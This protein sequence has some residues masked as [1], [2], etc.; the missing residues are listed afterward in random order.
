MFCQGRR[1]T[2]AIVAS[3]PGVAYQIPVVW[4]VIPLARVPLMDTRRV[5]FTRARNLCRVF[6]SLGYLKSPFVCERGLHGPVES[7]WH[8]VMAKPR[9][10]DSSDFFVAWPHPMRVQNAPSD[11]IDFGHDGVPMPIKTAPSCARLL[12]LDERCAVSVKPELGSEVGEHLAR[13]VARHFLFR[14]YLV[15][16]QRVFSARRFCVSGGGVHLGFAAL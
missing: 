6:D 8:N 7:S 13:V 9:L 5:A 11:G 14:G 12:V 10:R 15:M 3:L 2:L 4:Q 1:E 16:S